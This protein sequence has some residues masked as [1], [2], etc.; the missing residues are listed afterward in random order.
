MDVSRAVRRTDELFFY[1][2]LKILLPAPKDREP[3]FFWQAQ[4]LNQRRILPD[5][6]YMVRAKVGLQVQRS[7]A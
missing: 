6:V 4:I 3:F 1:K 7:L 2:L 5:A